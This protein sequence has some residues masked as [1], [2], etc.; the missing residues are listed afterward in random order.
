MTLIPSPDK[1]VRELDELKLVG[2]RVLCS[3]DDYLAEIPKAS[4]RLNERLSEI[5]HV[6][7]SSEQIG[8]FVVESE[9]ECMDGY[10]VC[11]EVKVFEDIPAGMVTLTVPSQRYASFRHKGSNFEIVQSYNELHRW[12]EDNN[13]NRLKN[14]WHL[15]KFYKWGNAEKLDV[16]LLDTIE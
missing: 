1:V 16:E 7:N 6:V 4:L 9:T 3:G 14:K 13:F 10:W 11:V 5:K 15:E 2:Y 12:I 8:A